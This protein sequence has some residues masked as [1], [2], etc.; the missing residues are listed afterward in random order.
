MEASFR[1]A[2]TGSGMVKWRLHTHFEILRGIPARIDVTPNE[3]QTA[4]GGW[5][6]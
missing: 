1:K 5:R 2:T 6:Q 3:K 4:G